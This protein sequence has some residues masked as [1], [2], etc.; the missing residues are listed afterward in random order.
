MILTVPE[1]AMLMPLLFLLVVMLPLV[2][3]PMII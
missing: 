3:I 2:A 1:P